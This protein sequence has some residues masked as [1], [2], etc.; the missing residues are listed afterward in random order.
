[1]VEKLLQQFLISGK[2]KNSNFAL[3]VC[4]AVEIALNN[5]KLS[6]ILTPYL[7]ANQQ[8]HANRKFPNRGGA[9]PSTNTHEG[10]K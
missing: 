10:D 6:R 8:F 7:P 2:N 3:F 5:A 1:V 4:F 9:E